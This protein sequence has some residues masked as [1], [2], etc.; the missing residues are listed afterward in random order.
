MAKVR[1]WLGVPHTPEWERA[2]VE[3]RLE[4]AEHRLLRLDATLPEP[5]ERRHVIVFP[6]PHRRATDR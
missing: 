3:R 6:H 4:E 1:E 2:D 5:R